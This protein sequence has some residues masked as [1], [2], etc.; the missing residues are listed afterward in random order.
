MSFDPEA[1]GLRMS[2]IVREYVEREV[3]PLRQRI[4][5]LEKKAAGNTSRQDKP[6]RRRR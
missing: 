5:K 1:F 6:K 2:D 3:A 4:A